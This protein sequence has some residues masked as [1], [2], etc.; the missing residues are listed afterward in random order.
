MKAKVKIMF[1]QLWATVCVTE[2]HQVHSN[3][4]QW[5]VKHKM[6]F[7]VIECKGKKCYTNVQ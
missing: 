3:Y 5:L 4:Q 7:I 1:I 2:Q 6:S